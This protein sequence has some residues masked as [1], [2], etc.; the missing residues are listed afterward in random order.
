MNPADQNPDLDVTGQPSSE[1]LRPKNAPI[2]RATSVKPGR[3][4]RKRT[5]R[6]FSCQHGG[7]FGEPSAGAMRMD[8]N[9]LKRRFFPEALVSV[10]ESNQ[11]LTR[12]EIRF[13]GTKALCRS[14]ILRAPVNLFLFAVSLAG[15]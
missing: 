15:V 10:A 5:A 9:G 6:L 2:D 14:C 8:E 1:P 4:V 11:P 13:A 12:K 7:A 3:V